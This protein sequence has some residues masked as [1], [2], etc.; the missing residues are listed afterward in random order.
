M[1]SWLALVVVCAAEASAAPISIPWQARLTD[2]LGAPLNG[3][4][5]VTLRVYSDTGTLRW[6][7][8]YSGLVALD[9]YVATM[10]G[11]TGTTGGVLDHGHF[12]GA[13]TIGVVVGTSPE[14]SP[15]TPV[16]DHPKAAAAVPLGTVISSL[17]APDA[18]NDFMTG[19]PQWALADGSLPASASSYTGLFPD[20]RG[21]F[22]R[23]MNAGRTDARKDPDT[24]T[25]GSQQI[26]AFQGHRHSMAEAWGFTGS[27]S[28]QAPSNAGRASVSSTNGPIDDGTNGAP[29]TASE[30][31]PGN[32]AVY[33]YVKVL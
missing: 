3:S 27:G 21:Q 2:S 23:G 25:V 16:G 22:L 4:V 19:N 15:R 20:L 28:N 11:G 30:T 5:D 18:S 24:R 31:R 1:R 14:L 33:W 9:G 6:E 17:V 8:P 10:M 13:A 29:R 12:D 26:D 32:V 7:R